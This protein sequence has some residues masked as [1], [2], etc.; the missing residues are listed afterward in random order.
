MGPNVCLLIP[1]L[2]VTSFSL[3]LAEDP[4]EDKPGSEEGL[5]VQGSEPGQRFIFISMR[6]D[7]ETPC[8]GKDC[9]LEG[10]LEG[11]PVHP[12]AELSF[13]DNDAEESNHRRS[14]EPILSGAGLR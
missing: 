3:A 7:Q 11:H 14:V 5:P 6:R 12:S 10:K 8:R 9:P 1:L 13:G 2:F 4:T